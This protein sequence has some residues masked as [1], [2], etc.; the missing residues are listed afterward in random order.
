MILAIPM[1]LLGTVAVIYFL[2]F[3]LNTFTMLAL[4]LAVG[5]VVDDAIMVLENIHRH[6]DQGKDRVRAAREGTREITFA[7]LAAT[8]AVVA[9]FIPVVFMKGVVG[10]VLP[11]VRRHPVR[12]GAAVVP[13]GHHPGPGALGPD[14]AADH[15][16]RNVVG[17][18]ADW[19]FDR[20]A[21]GY[22]WTAEAGAALAGHGAAAVGGADGGRLVRAARDADRVRAPRRTRAA[23]TCACRRR[24]GRT[25]R[26]PTS[27]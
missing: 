10:Q 9:I 8:L 23:S 6:F 3:T 14:P 12:G 22:A 1:S 27:C 15:A 2:G 16:E 17:R 21:R 18:G 11:A 24:S 7:A 5:I 13:G 4:S 25:S 26:R 20:L 19:A